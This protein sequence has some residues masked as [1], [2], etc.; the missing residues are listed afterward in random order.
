MIR[1]IIDRL[2]ITLKNKTLITDFSLNAYQG[3]IIALMGSNGA[4]KTTLLKTLAGLLP[5]TTSSILIDGHS[6]S[7]Y[8]W[9]HRAQII[10][11]LLQ[12]STEHHFCTGQSRIAHGLIPSLGFDFYIDDEIAASI[13]KMASRLKIDHLLSRRLK[14]MSGGEQ[15]LIHLAK[16][17]INSR[18][19]IILLDEPSVFLDQEQQQNLIAN[20]KTES[21]NHKLIF[22]SSH[23][24]LFIKRLAHRII[25][26]ENKRCNEISTLA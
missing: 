10:S 6:S 12:H 26:I 20:L 18:S 8:S 11:F 21:T 4:G 13:R 14:D 1:L 24:E 17:F 2:T 23:D 15:R 7:S 16:T 25:R 19:K 5:S 22:F 9:T 3:E